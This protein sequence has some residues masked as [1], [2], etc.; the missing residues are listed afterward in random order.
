MVRPSRTLLFFVITLSFLALLMLVFPNDGIKINKDITL[1]FPD[2]EDFFA[3]YNAPE[4]DSTVSSKII[5]SIDEDLN[6]IEEDTL[7]YVF[8]EEIVDSSVYSFKPRAIMTDSIRQPLELPNS[9]LACLQPLFAAL[10]NPDELKHVV[11]IMHYGDSQIETDRITNYL[12]Y[13]LQQQFGGSGPG[14]IPAK[15]AYGYKSPCEVIN[16]GEWTRYTVFPKIDTAVG[17]SRYGVLAA[18]GMFSPLKKKTLEPNLTEKKDTI[19]STDSTSEVAT[20]EEQ[21]Q[22]ETSQ[23]EIQQEIVDNQ[24]VYKGSLTI[25]PS[26]IARAGVKQ[27]KK[28]RMLYGNCPEAFEARVYDGE[29]LLFAEKLRAENFYTTKLWNFDTPPSTLKF[30]FSAKQSPE[31]YGFALDGLSGVAVDNIA[32]RGCSGT[33]FTMING[34]MLA[35]MYKE[36]NVKCAILQFGGNAVPY[37][38]E[39]KLN[40][41]KNSFAAQIRYLKKLCPDMAII[42]VGPA[43]MSEKVQ[44]KYQTYEILPAVVEALKTAALNNNCAFWDMYAAMG[45]ENT[46][47][48]WVYHDPQ[49]AEK[50]FVHFTPNG[51]N[52]MARMLYSAI[53]SRYNEYIRKK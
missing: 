40:G 46:M 1:F 11:R 28:C 4:K 22:E 34:K 9:G 16:E 14:L 17:H 41:F 30:E 35:Q 44:D 7:E 47:P 6:A 36:L 43:D 2:F 42:V 26:P 52:V 23:V 39:E 25:I 32:L 45:G 49:L 38:T 21:L 10:T 19:N 3:E 8:H 51:A 37:M 33:I 29:N 53:I 20:K 31:I 27:I 15:T 18:F 48:D 13:K 24:T 50:D 12:R 5:F